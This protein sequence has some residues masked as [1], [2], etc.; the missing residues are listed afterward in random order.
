MRRT[1][2]AP[3]LQRLQGKARRRG[4]E[5]GPRPVYW[6]PKPAH[7]LAQG[8]AREVTLVRG[9]EDLPIELTSVRVTRDG[10]L[11]LIGDLAVGIL[12]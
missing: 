12:G 3:E 2:L 6:R 5:T 11:R 8:G 4:N 9:G 10:D 1:G 7:P